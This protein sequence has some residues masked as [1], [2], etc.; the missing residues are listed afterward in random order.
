MEIE[1]LTAFFRWS[2]I[3]NGGL[4]FLAAAIIGAAPEFLYRSQSRWFSISRENH[5]VVIYC[6]LGL[7]KIF[8][9]FFNLVPYLALLIVGS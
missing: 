5:A 1:T 9:L 8:F 3:L 6:F 7:F 2:T 4:L